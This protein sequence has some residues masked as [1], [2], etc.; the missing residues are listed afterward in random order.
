MPYL[1]VCTDMQVFATCDLFERA[2]DL[3]D[4]ILA[5]GITPDS[6]GLPVLLSCDKRCDLLFCR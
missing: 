6:V 5:D 3:Y 1:C 4:D 2:C